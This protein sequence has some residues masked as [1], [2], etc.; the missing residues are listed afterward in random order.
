MPVGSHP[1]GR[2]PEGLDD[3]IGNVWEWTATEFRPYGDA[4]ARSGLYVIRGGGYNSLDVISTAVFRGRAQPATRRQDLAATG[5]RCAQ[6][7][8]SA[9]DRG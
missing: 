7:P 9:E 2:T 1:S 5:F 4:S 3:M 6:T 8:R